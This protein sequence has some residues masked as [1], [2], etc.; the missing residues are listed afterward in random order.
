MGG[1][2]GIESELG[3]GS[4]FWFTLN[5]VLA[6]VKVLP[7][8]MQDLSHEKI[9]LVDDNETNRQVFGQ[10]LSA[11]KVPHELVENGS[12]AL[13]AMYDA[14]AIKE[15]YT[16]AL[17]DMQMPGMDGA[18]LG[19]M[20]R[21][22]QQFLATHLALLTSQGQRGDAQ[23]LHEQGFSAYLCKPIRQAELY[24]S[25]LQL[26]GLQGDAISDT[27]ITRYTSARQGPRFQAK[28]LVVDDN[29][30][31]QLVAKGMLEKFGMT[32]EL[33]NNGQE[34]IDLLEQ[35]DYDLI[36]MD[37]Q[38]PVMDGY[39]AT[40]TIRSPQSKVKNH[41]VTVVAMTAN[42]MQGDREKCF[43]SGMDDFIAKPVELIKLVKI[44][45]KWLAKEIAIE[46][47]VEKIKEEGLNVVEDEIPIFDYKAMSE[48]L[49]NDKE[50]IAIIA[51]TFLKDMPVQIDHLKMLV[52]EGDAT[53]I[54]AQAHKIKGAAS[55]VGA[56]HLIQSALKMEQ[57]GKKG[58][59]KNVFQDLTM[60]EQ[61]FIQISKVMKE[62]IK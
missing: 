51:D 18:K 44:L 36:F 47:P 57:A 3:K 35:S 25:L 61:S 11:W 42:A 48:R 24:S 12:A 41:T 23:K 55:N 62:T 58:N 33:A 21:S 59:M 15:P 34:A 54:A 16:I 29:N 10:F 39:L 19:E 32:V 13:Q 28:V 22:E 60:L 9:L 8:K 7:S 14:V 43:K 20:I 40:E 38:M 27:L 56:M 49:M 53:K 31:N 45:E 5:L 52:E 4:T 17:I 1:E 46:K 26:A 37:C 2:I 6:K 50:L 30:I